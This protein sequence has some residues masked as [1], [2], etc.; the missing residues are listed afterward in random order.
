MYRS[1]LDTSTDKD[2]QI[3][4]NYLF[5]FYL[6]RLIKIQL[7][8]LFYFFFKHACDIYTN[9]IKTDQKLSICEFEIID[10]CS[11][12]NVSAGDTN[13]FC[14]HDLITL[15]ILKSFHFSYLSNN[16]HILTLS[17]SYTGE[18]KHK[19]HL[20]HFKL[21]HMCNTTLWSMLI[22]CLVCKFLLLLLILCYISCVIF[23]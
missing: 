18:K 11:I 17:L 16:I 15:I 20:K 23:S 9:L 19:W 1:I 5:S 10:V 7:L 22:L 13:L 14:L 2:E 21:I 3:K 12:L 8:L 4:R 6:F